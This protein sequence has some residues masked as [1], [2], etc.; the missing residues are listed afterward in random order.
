MIPIFK[1]LGIKTVYT[2][3]KIKGEDVIDGIK[4]MACPLYAVN[5]EDPERNNNFLNKDFQT[6]ERDILYSFIGG[7]APG[8]LTN[9]RKRIFDMQHNDTNTVVKNTGS[10]HFDKD[11]YFGE[12]GIEGKLNEDDE[13]KLKTKYYNETLLR[14]KFSLS[15]SGSGPN[16]IRLWESLACGSIPVLLADTLDLPAHDLWN[17]AIV[18][19]KERDVKK[20]PEILNGISEERIGEMRKNCLKIYQDFKENFLNLKVDRPIVHYCDG[21]YEKGYVGGVARYDY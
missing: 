11:V 15:P 8:Y 16:S 18:K 6:Q 21:C 19:V 4:I 1:T 10:W 20:I 9:I 7:F 2:P 5:I 3:H 12:Q 17:D 14:S 13:H